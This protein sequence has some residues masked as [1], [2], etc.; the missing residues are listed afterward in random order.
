VDRPHVCEISGKAF[1]R[2]GNLARHMR[3]HTGERP[4]VCEVCGKAFSGSG[5]TA[6]HFSIILVCIFGDFLN[7]LLGCIFGDF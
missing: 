7:Q 6:G 5:G 3:T 1:E 2:S 4:H